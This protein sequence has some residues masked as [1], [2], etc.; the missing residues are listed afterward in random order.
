MA[1]RTPGARISAP[2]PG[3]QSGGDQ[4][5]QGVERGEAADAGDVRHFGRSEGVQAYLRIEAL[6]CREELLV[7]IDP[8]LRV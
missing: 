1:F 6:E 8:Q 7:E 5:F 4:P 2:A 3:V